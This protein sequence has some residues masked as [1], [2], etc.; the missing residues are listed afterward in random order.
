MILVR[1]IGPGPGSGIQSLGP[2]SG[3]RV[4]VEMQRKYLRAIYIKTGLGK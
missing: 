2:V 4:V 1:K 3:I